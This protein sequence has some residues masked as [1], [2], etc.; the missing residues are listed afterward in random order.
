M[1]R[2]NINNITTFR[3]NLSFYYQST[4]IYFI[5]FVVYI[6][7]RGEFVE[8]S[9]TLITKDPIIYFFGIIV[10]ISI[11]GLLY[12]LY[13]K[14]HI[15]VNEEGIAFI[16]RNGRKSFGRNDIIWIKLSKAAEVKKPLRLIRIKLKNR[17]RPL[18]IRPYDYENEAALVTRFEELKNIVE[19]GSNKN[20]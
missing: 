20:V 19:K 16:N 9:F 2:E 15:E 7:I 17:R 13:R 3:Y 8:N 4:L 14:K 10:L 6:V 18:L 1:S 11:I 12:N 5:V